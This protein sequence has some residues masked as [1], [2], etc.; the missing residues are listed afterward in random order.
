MQEAREFHSPV[1]GRR[2]TAPPA[3]GFQWDGLLREQ[4]GIADRS[5][6]TPLERVIT[7]AAAGTICGIAWWGVISFIQHIPQVIHWLDGVL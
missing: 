1:P 6:A 7:Y 5:K 3:P 4:A 2:F